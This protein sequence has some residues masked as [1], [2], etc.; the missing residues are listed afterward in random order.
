MK[1]I[2]IGIL[3]VVAVLYLSFLFVI[4]NVVNLNNYTGLVAE[5]AKK[6]TGLDMTINDAKFYTTPA[7]KAGIRVKDIQIKYPSTKVLVDLDTADIRLKLLPLLILSVQVDKVVVGE[8]T[9]NV[10]LNKD[11][12]TDVENYFNNLPSTPKTNEETRAVP[13]RISPK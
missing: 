12:T 5:E 6:A 11:G 13:A 9:L 7:F 3:A 8:P 10:M 1:K 4:P 2:G